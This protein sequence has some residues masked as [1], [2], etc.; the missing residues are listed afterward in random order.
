MSW[1]R[2]LFWLVLAVPA[3]LMIAQLASGAARAMD[4]YHPSGEMSLRL[5]VIAL[6]AGPVADIFGRNRFTRG[7]LAIRRN[8]GV[9][10]FCYAAL[11][12][13]FYVIDLRTLA[14]ML[15]ELTLPA[16]WTGWLG[17]A[18]M[19]AAASISTDAAMRRLG[20]WWKRIQLGVYAAV[21]LAALHWALLDREAG[22]ALIHLAPLLVLWPLRA[23]ILYS[24]RTTRGLST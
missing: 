13:V 16:I 21:L 15:D 17:F 22:P 18:F 14:A 12:L 8:L 6:M 11:H 3:G 2:A 5:M 23:V 9:A 10:A 19:L 20:H 1:K 7:W 4:L 24:R